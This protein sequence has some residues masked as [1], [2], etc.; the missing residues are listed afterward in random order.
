[1]TDNKKGG[2][3]KLAIA[4]PKATNSAI[5]ILGLL[6]LF[7]YAGLKKFDA[8]LNFLNILSI[9]R[10]ATLVVAIVFK[11]LGLA[12]M[13]AVTINFSIEA[14][15]RK[16]HEEEKKDLIETINETHKNQREA[17]IKAI[18]ERIFQTV[19]ERNIPGGFFKAI[20]EHMLKSNFLRINSEYELEINNHG[21]DHVEITSRHTFFIQNIS[22]GAAVY[23]M[24]LGFDV[25]K[26]L[27]ENYNIKTLSIGA[28]TSPLPITPVVKDKTGMHEWWEV[29]FDRKLEKDETARCVV[30][31][32][33]IST[34]T[35]KEAICAMLPT[36][37]M[38]IRLIDM[39]RSLSIRAMTLHP[40][41][42]IERRVD[43]KGGRYHW[44]I[45]GALFPG[46]GFLIDWAPRTTQTSHCAA[47]SQPQP[48]SQPEPEPKPLPET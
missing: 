47:Q 7:I 8:P 23:V 11:E 10:D 39:T 48:L 28:S 4:N 46:H 13:V 34:K 26:S 18:N 44:E 30:E 32:V 37:K 12:A 35:G 41:P 14:F 19:Y 43:E 27:K 21:E 17:Q 2:V 38:S 9:S 42:E 31:Y 22:S 36:Q 1:M 29:Q 5:A 33:R 16:R 3:L 40:R 24:K 20:E 25:I 45:D 15:N 6:S